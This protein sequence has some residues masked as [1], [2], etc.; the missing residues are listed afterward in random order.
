MRSLLRHKLKILLGFYAALLIASHI[1]VA[2][3]PART[4]LVDP[5]KELI[6]LP[7]TTRDGPVEGESIN[8]PFLEWWPREPT[9]LPPVILIHGS[10]GDAT[11]FA[12]GPGFGTLSAGLGPTLADDRDV[13]ALDM[14]G[15]GDHT[16]PVPS[17]A[18]R[19][20][21]HAVL[22]FMDAKGIDRAH[23]VGWSQGGA[24]VLNAADIAPQRTASITLLAAVGC[25]ETEGSGDYYF[26]HAKYAIG[27]IGAHALDWVVPD[28]GALG[29]PAL[30]PL[31]VSMHNFWDTDQRPLGAI[32][33]T[34]EVPSLILHGRDDFLI[35]W[36]AAERHHEL[37]PTSSLVMTGAGHFMPFTQPDAVAE[38]LSPFF[39]RHDEPGVEPRTTRTDLAPRPPHPFGVVGVW[40]ER[41]L[42]TAPWPMVALVFALMAFLHPTLAAAIAGLLVATLNEDLGVALVGLVTGH[43]G[44]QLIKRG[45]PWPAIAVPVLA[46]ILAPMVAELARPLP[47]AVRGIAWVLA[48]LALAFLLWFIPNLARKPGRTKL[49]LTFA[50]LRHHEFWPAWLFYIPLVPWLIY[51]SLRHG[52]VRSFTRCNPGITALGGVGG[53]IVGESK[54]RIQ[55]RLGDHPAV[56]KTTLIEADPDTDTRLR[57]TLGAIDGY[58][59]IL[60]PDAGQRGYAVRLAR[61]ENDVRDYVRGFARDLVVQTYHPGPHECG[62]FWVRDVPDGR[63][64][65]ITRKDFPAITG[66]GVRTLEQLIRSHTRYRLQE[67]TFRPRFAERWNEVLA[68]GETLR[69][70]ESG[71]HSQG[72]LFR[73]GSDLMTP[74]L[75]QAVREIASEFEG[76]DFGRF[77]LRYE[78]DESLKR[79]E[80]FG[81]VELN[82]ITSESTNLYD[83]EIDAIAAYRILFEQWRI[84]YRIGQQ[85]KRERV[86]PVR[87]GELLASLRGFY[88]DRPDTVAS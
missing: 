32:M 83:P 58:P 6:E 8:L 62:V 57:K 88:V 33:G 49:R 21:A 51:L 79:G 71:N 54:A 74:R 44:R 23:L 37:M 46:M 52:G 16:E 7:A 42:H 35:S 76:F 87:I 47:D 82:G 75:E 14:P 65:S 67:D 17:R 18:S 86:A 39:V 61:C 50:R 28:F 41:F 60:K 40:G 25:Q 55:R 31:R 80:G 3:R 15:M 22:A 69:L 85:R 66:D 9:G 19:A 45:R 43:G 63:I 34:T 53:G 59:V 73:D 2:T 72:T 4:T 13:Y 36:W 1:T 30:R 64:F 10:P 12:P 38:H 48:A 81:V 26:E 78:S 24:V 77:D 27:V 5:R 70:T 29:R 11:N 20:H 56:L 84:A 68:Q